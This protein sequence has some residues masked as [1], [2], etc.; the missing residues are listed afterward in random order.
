MVSLP[1]EPGAAANPQMSDPERALVQG[2][3][4]G[5]TD[6]GKR[7]RTGSQQGIGE[8]SGKGNSRKGDGVQPQGEDQ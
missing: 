1:R 4:V 6:P 8:R 2:D 7:P 5:E 3:G